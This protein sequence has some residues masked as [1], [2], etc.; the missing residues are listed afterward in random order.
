MNN[1]GRPDIVFSTPLLAIAEFSGIGVLLNTSP[2]NFSLSATTFSPSPVTA[3]NSLNATIGLTSNF[4]FN[5]TVTLVCSG[6]P[7]GATCAFSPASVPGGTA[8]SL[9]TIVT[10]SNTAP[11]IYPIEVQASA[12]TITRQVAL[13][14]VVQRAPDF[15]ITVPPTAFQ[16]VSAGQKQGLRSYRADEEAP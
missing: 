3:G 9:L 6:L 12:G 4:G 7:S 16:I 2:A 1:D 5:Q 13:T 8:T 14:L 15:A 10:A 11:G